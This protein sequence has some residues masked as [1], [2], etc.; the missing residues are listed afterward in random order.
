MNFHSSQTNTLNEFAPNPSILEPQD[1]NTLVSGLKSREEN[2]IELLDRNLKYKDTI[3]KKEL[4]K[5]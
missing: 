4:N 1:L 2:V 3:N 5:L